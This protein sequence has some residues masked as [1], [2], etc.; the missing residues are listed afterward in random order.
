MSYI[1]PVS[2]FLNVITNSI[3]IATVLSFIV[4]QI[5]KVII[6]IIKRK[7]Y[8]YQAFYRMYGGMPSTHTAVVSTV[9]FSILLIDGVTTLFM[10]SLFWS[11]T[12]ISD[13]IGVKWFFTPR[14]QIFQ[15]LE[16]I[17]VKKHHKKLHSIP[18]EVG[19]T[20]WDVII[21]III[22]ILTSFFVFIFL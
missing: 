9:T 2:I 15:E 6:L 8:A 16:K 21:G 22:A 13:V 14:N 17:I 7:P 12:I 10:F 18:M 1:N 3:F 4:S 20:V 5:F 11:I 19:H